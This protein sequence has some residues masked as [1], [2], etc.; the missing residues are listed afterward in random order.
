MKTK[1]KTVDVVTV[2]SFDT[3]A[4]MLRVKNVEDNASTVEGGR[5]EIME[6]LAAEFGAPALMT[7]KNGGINCAAFR[8]GTKDETRK[9]EAS[10]LG[11]STHKAAQLA[12]II[13]AINTIR[14]NIWQEY[15][16]SYFGRA[17]PKASAPA[18]LTKEAKEANT[19]KAEAKEA[20][21]QV[22]L[23]RAA[24]IVASVE[25]KGVE[26][27]K[28]NLEEKKAKAEDAKAKADEAKAKAIEAKAETK[29]AKASESLADIIQRAIDMAEKAGKASVMDLLTEALD[30]L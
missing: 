17:T 12:G 11:M 8:K 2:P 3:D 29:E 21:T 22:A 26:E 24:L 23:A 18:E 5:K 9:K 19:A 20:K 10:R 16:R 28:A 27:A 4:L 25:K 14:H 1:T 6:T 30:S 7:A 15:Q 13:T